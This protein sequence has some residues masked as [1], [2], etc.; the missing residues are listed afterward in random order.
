MPAAVDRRDLHSVSRGYAP[1]RFGQIHFRVCRA[2]EPRKPPLFCLHHVPNSGQ[3]FEPVLPY[4]AMGRDVYALDLPGFGMSDPAPDPQAIGHYALAIADA[5]TALGHANDALDV[6]G[7]HTGAAVATQLALDPSL[8]IRRV[9][10][11]AVPVFSAEERASFGAQTPIPF[12]EQ[13]EWAREEWRRSWHW[14]G[15]MQSRDS[16]LRTYAEKMRPGARERGA[17]AIVSFDMGAALQQIRQP[18]MLMRPHDDL[19]EATGR[20][21][22]LRADARHIELAEFAHGLWEAD[23]ERLASVIE[24]FLDATP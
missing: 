20:A 19:W 12:D 4:L 3:I 6:L 5:I 17:R 14:R 23:P 1:C 24:D 9:V 22:A 11:T 13:G 15:P 21:M 16:V 18:L 2:I 7:Y 8:R 10:L